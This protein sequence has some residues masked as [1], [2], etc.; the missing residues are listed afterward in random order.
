MTN[1]KFEMTRK[2]KEL[3]DE[4]LKLDFTIDNNYLSD[5]ITETWKEKRDEIC[6]KIKHIIESDSYELSMYRALKLQLMRAEY[7]L[8][9]AKENLKRC[10][11]SWYAASQADWNTW[12]YIKLTEK[13]NKNEKFSNNH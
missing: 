7:N 12:N 10:E 1:H 9:L 6:S 4:Y 5:D 11:A 3:Y 13:E 8:N 2:E